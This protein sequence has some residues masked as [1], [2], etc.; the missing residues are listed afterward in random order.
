MELV[1]CQ[2]NQYKNIQTVK[3]TGTGHHTARIGIICFVVIE[4]FKH[5]GKMGGKG[6]IAQKNL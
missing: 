1:W 6:S 4:Q 3:I 5:R 2:A